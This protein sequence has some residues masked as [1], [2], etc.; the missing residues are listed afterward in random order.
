M[1]NIKGKRE[2]EKRSPILHLHN[3]IQLTLSCQSK[4]MDKTS[5]NEFEAINSNRDHFGL[6]KNPLLLFKI[7]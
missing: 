6:P 4:H 1:E 5:Y 2:R 7:I 3:T